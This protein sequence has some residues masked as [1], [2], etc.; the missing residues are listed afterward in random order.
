MKITISSEMSV[1]WLNKFQMT[2][3]F[4]WR[5]NFS[6]RIYEFIY[7]EWVQ[8]DGGMNHRNVVSV[9]PDKWQENK[10]ANKYSCVHAN[11]NGC[12][13]TNDWQEP[14]ELNTSRSTGV[15]GWWTGTLTTV[16]IP[17]IIF[18]LVLHLWN[19]L[20]SGFSLFP[21]QAGPILSE[22]SAWSIW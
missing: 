3:S 17:I 1:S 8:H 20:F 19:C 12:L 11:V 21:W 4:T 2:L 5:P 16:T 9:P 13:A 7:N 15:A 14:H 18:G 6:F 22:S 10:Q